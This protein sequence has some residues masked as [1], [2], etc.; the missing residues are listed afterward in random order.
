MVSNKNRHLG[1]YDTQEQALQAYELASQ[2]GI[3]PE[4]KSGLGVLDPNPA[5]QPAGNIMGEG[6]IKSQY[7]GVTWNK[8]KGKWQTRI[9]RN[10]RR[11]NLGFYARDV[12]AHAAYMAAKQAMALEE[13]RQ[14]PS[15]CSQPC[16][17]PHHVVGGGGFGGAG[18]LITAEPDI[19]IYEKQ[20]QTD[21]SFITDQ[22]GPICKA[23]NAEYKIDTVH[24]GICDR[25]S[26]GDAVCHEAKKLDADGVVI[27]KHQQGPFSELLLGSVTKHCINHC[28][29]PVVV[30]H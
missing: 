4:R 23:A 9:C 15:Q 13:Q 18:D 5:H 30:L 12:D 1:Y 16:K 10:G 28:K 22:Y 20:I 3:F 25:H 27:M 14:M 29:Q 11:R 24:R 2:H 17:D 21:H 19:A 6:R 7:P 8:N 26:I